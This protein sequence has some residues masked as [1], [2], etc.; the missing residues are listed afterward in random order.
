MLASPLGY[1][2]VV[3]VGAL[4]TLTG[5][6]TPGRATI[7]IGPD[8]CR[9]VSPERLPHLGQ[10][11]VESR[12]GETDEGAP[13]CLIGQ[14][15]RPTLRPE[16][17]L[18]D[19]SPGLGFE[20]LEKAFQRIGVIV[21]RD[22]GARDVVE[23]EAV[24]HGSLEQRKNL[25]LANARVQLQ[26]NQIRARGEAPRNPQIACQLQRSLDGVDRERRRRAR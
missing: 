10:Q 20:C 19:E 6:L 23:S 21:G 26:A 2:C 12:I 8:L 15:W 9:L 22:V 11:F 13:S 5:E 4:S 24:V 3:T 18:E 17:F 7:A 25:W 14:K 1:S 16:E